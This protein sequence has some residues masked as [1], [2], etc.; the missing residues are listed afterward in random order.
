MT[1]SDDIV[2]IW[3]RCSGQEST[4]HKDHKV[5]DRPGLRAEPT[6]LRRIVHLAQ[7]ILLLARFSHHRAVR[8]YSARDCRGPARVR[9]RRTFTST[10]VATKRSTE[11]EQVIVVL[12]CAT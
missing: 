3:S 1:G 12:L 11:S 9:S 10:R 6:Q 5:N 4:D 8:P 2:R 7:R